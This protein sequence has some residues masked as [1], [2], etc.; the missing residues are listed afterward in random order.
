MAAQLNRLVEEAAALVEAKA[1]RMGASVELSLDPS[2]PIMAL[3]AGLLVQALTNLM[4]HGLQSMA[5]SPMKR[6]RVA[7]RLAGERLQVVVQD[8]GSTLP[9]T[10]QGE[11]FDPSQA[12]S[13]E[14]LGLPIADLITRQHG[15]QLSARSQEGLG[16]AFLLELPLGTP[17]PAVVAAPAGPAGLKGVRTLVVDDETFLLECL[18]DALDAWGVKATPST[19]GDEAIQQLQEGDFDLI[20]SDIR[21][22]GLSGMELYEWLKAQR[23]GMTRRILYTTGDA[24]DAKTR[25][26]LEATQVPY[27]GKPFDLSQLKQSL[28]RLLETPVDA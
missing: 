6:M 27:L 10:R 11:L 3:D 22:P 28:E 14:A 12:T 23:P 17:P 7:T 15:G 9:E 25:Q 5:M 26:F 2:L 4:L 20:V 18:V 13:T 19:R 16:N 24:F 1:L 21:M 8:T